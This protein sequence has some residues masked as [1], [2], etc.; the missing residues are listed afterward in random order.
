MSTSPQYVW[1][2]HRTHWMSTDLLPPVVAAD[3][4]RPHTVADWTVPT[5]QG[6]T[7]ITVAGR[8]SWT[9]PPPAALVWPVYLVLLAATVL[10]GWRAR[11]P[12]PLAVALAVGAVA[13][14]YHAGT[15]PEPASSVSSH[16]GALVAALLPALLVLLV[17]AVGLR[18][19]RRRRTVLTGLMAVWPAGCCWCRVCPTSTCCGPPTR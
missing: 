3:P 10:A 4:G 1:H 2:D 7:E 14:L 16:A 17:A 19:A 9:P 12:R 13:S 5:T 18:A 6:G 15:T 11:G 8:L